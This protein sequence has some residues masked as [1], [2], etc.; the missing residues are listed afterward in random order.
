MEEFVFEAKI[1]S[2]LIHIH[3]HTRTHKETRERK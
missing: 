2:A 1:H 3:T